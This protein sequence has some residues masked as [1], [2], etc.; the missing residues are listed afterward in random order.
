MYVVDA[1]PCIAQ[2]HVSTGKRPPDVLDYS[3]IGR[4]LYIFVS[5]TKHLVETGRL[6]RLRH[7]MAGKSPREYE[8]ARSCGGTRWSYEYIE[9]SYPL[10]VNSSNLAC[11]SFRPRGSGCTCRRGAVQVYPGPGRGARA[12]GPSSFLRLALCVDQVRTRATVCT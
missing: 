4:S 12:C 2:P 8:T 5:N 3:P 1:G 9:S 10:L 7:E 11:P 6:V